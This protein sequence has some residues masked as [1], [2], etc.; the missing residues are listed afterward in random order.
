MPAPERPQRPTIADRLTRL[1]YAQIAGWRDDDHALAFA[2][3]LRSAHQ[4]VETPPTK[5]H[6]AIDLNA[7]VAVAHRAILSGPMTAQTARRF[8][9]EHF[10]PARIDAAGFVTG[11]YEPELAASPVRTGQFPVPIHKRPPDLIDV[12][13]GN[14]P[15]GWDPEIRFGRQTEDGIEPYFDRAAI[16]DGAL[17]G[18]G[19]ELAW[20]ADPVDAYFV[21]IQGSA[22]LRMAGGGLERI[23]FDG[24]SGH[25]YTSI[26]KLAVERGY[27]SVAAAD[28]AGLE[29]WLRQN[30]QDGRQLMQQNRSY[31][32]FRQTPPA[33]LEQGPIGAAGIPLTAG[34]S[35]AIDRKL[36]TFHTPL[37][38]DAAGIPDPDAP[39]G[40]AA[41]H[42]RRLMIAQDTGSAIV[43]PAR[44][45]LFYGSGKEAG[46]RA[47]RVRHRAAMTLLLPKPVSGKRG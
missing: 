2:A 38:V 26:G 25:A 16:E 10:E 4:I 33:P 47:G 37:W 28:K 3:F 39:T 24:K 35:L 22:R 6:R 40:A 42:F 27:L 30:R 19:L 13:G 9:E 12:D 17:A 46:D 1:S 21:H 5:R 45:D 8:F 32:F 43:G 41:T 23:A 36:V 18:K 7:L 20:L 44:G 14:R 34:R 31:I 29:T 11:Y 15:A